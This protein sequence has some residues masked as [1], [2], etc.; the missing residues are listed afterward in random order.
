[1]NEN[2]NQTIAENENQ[3]SENNMDKKPDESFSVLA[4]RMNSIEEML[5]NMGTMISTIQK[6]QE[7]FVAL[8]GSIHESTSMDSDDDVDDSSDILPLDMLDWNL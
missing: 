3:N 6:A 2:E 7:S 5:T 4:D 1:M 8:G